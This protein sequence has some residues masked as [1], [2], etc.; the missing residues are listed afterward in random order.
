MKISSRTRRLF[1][2]KILFL[3]SAFIALTGSVAQADEIFKVTGTGT[4]GFSGDGGP[5]VGAQVSNPRGVAVDSLGNIYIADSA[6]HRIRMITPGGTISTFAGTGV[7]GFTD[8]S[9]GLSLAVNAQLNEPSDVTVDG[10]DNV[11]IADRLN[12]RIRKVDAVGVITTVAGDG[13]AE[14]RPHT[15]CV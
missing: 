3:A 6:N 14:R 12:R 7:G 5:A 2:P 10:S 15:D 4:S 11:Y 13:G 9:D 1:L 8:D